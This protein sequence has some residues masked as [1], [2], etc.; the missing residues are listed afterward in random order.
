[1]GNDGMVNFDENIGLVYYVFNKYYQKYRDIEDDL[2]QE[3]MIGLWKACQ[4]FDSLREVKFSTYAVKVI[5]NSMGM[6]VRKE[7]RSREECSLDRLVDADRKDG[8]R[9]TFLNLMPY[10]AQEDLRDVIEVLL[11]VAK[12]NNCEEIVKMKL[13]GMKQVDI[14]KELGVHQSTISEKLRRLYALVR[15]EL[16]IEE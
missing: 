15:K 16:G 8:K 13:D 5:K 10:D 2:I 3:G 12:E 14:A 11:E 4:T 9:V 1:M 7:A 6:Y